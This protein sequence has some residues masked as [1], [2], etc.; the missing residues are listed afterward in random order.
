MQTYLNIVQII[1]SVA[2]IA[3]VLLEVRSSGLGGPF[4]GAQS[5]LVRRRRGPE[6][7]ILRLTVITSVLFFL[8]AV[9]NL[10]VSG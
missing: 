7:L 1:L 3:L 2:L 9:V 10:L 5:G 8:T 4:G 6:L